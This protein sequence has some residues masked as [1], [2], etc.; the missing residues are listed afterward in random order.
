MQILDIID[1]KIH[2]PLRENIF[3]RQFNKQVKAV[4]GI[5]FSIENGSVLGIVGESGC[6]KSTLAR[7]IAKLVPITSGKILFQG[8]D[9]K[10]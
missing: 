10:K 5:S 9:I 8:D 3:F 4:D 6:G 7:S 1:L 2:F